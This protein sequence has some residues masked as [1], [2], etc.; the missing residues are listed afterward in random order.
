MQRVVEH[1]CVGLLFTGCQEALAQKAFTWQEIR[2][3]FEATNPT[4]RAGQMNIDESKAS[5][6]TA[7]LRPNPDMTA[8]LDQFAPFTA[9][10]YRPFGYLFP[11]LEFSYLHER[12]H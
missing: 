12:Q 1:L 2:D 8:G 4:L 11:L 5:E 7:Y 9:N 10:P 6:I 3:K